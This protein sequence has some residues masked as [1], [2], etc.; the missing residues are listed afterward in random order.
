MRNRTKLLGAASACAACCAVSILPAV[1][2]GGGLAALG[3]AVFVGNEVF[4]ITLTL[5]AAGGILVW[6]KRSASRKTAEACGCGGSCSESDGTDRSCALPTKLGA[7]IIA[8]P[9]RLDQR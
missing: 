2:A 7:E 4:A 8:A 9:G 3:G 5:V 6:H 1:L